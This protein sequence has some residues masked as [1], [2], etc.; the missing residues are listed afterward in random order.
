MTKIWA[1]KGENVEKK[2]TIFYTDM[3][4]IAPVHDVPFII[5]G[6]GDEEQA[7]QTNE[8]ASL[9]SLKAVTEAYIEYLET[10]CL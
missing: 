1:D 6:P 3:S 8:N 4:Q 7:H 2:G 5:F 10:Y 9:M